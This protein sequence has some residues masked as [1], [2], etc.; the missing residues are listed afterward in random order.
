MKSTIDE[1][2]SNTYKKPF[3]SIML[4]LED[5]KQYSNGS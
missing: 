5:V 2:S 3:I 1:P 4:T